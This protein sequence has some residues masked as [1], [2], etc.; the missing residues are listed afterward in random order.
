MPVNM[1]MIKAALKISESLLVAYG[2]TD[3]GI[4]SSMQITDWQGYVNHDEGVP[5]SG[6]KVK[7][8][9]LEDETVELPVNQVGTK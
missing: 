3:F 9:S 7:V 8:V 4:V 5:S 6:V 2:A 1:V